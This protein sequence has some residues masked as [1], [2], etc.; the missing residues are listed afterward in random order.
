MLSA[1]AG[2]VVAHMGD[3]EDGLGMVNRV[4]DKTEIPIRT[5][6]PT[7][8]NRKKELLMESFE[9]AKKVE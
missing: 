6:R 8:V 4:L 7:H 3:G 2:I 1:K 5:I 9:Y